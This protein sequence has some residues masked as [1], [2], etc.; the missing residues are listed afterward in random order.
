MTNEQ[1]KAVVLLSGGL[2]STTTLAIAKAQGFSLYALTVDYGQR[3]RFEVLRAREVAER[4]G[5]VE[6]KIIAIDLRTF[7]G[8]SLTSDLAV[9][10]NRSVDELGD[11]IPTTYVPVRNILL[12]SYALAWAEV[13]NASDI[14]IGVNCIDTSGYPD[15]RPEFI[16]AFAAMA[17]LG[18]KLGT[19]LG[20]R[21]SVHAPLQDLN[22][23]QIIRL[24]LQLDVDYGITMTCYAP[25]NDG[26]ACAECDA[27]I[28]RKRGF[29]QAG[30][31]DPIR[32]AK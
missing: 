3:N 6:H 21:I 11:K 30:I 26:T 9:E 24:G 7:G 15:C 17:N 28:L 12:L 25:L 5:V 8:S 20:V 22:K 4:I 29:A 19:E 18:T 23:G 14:F 27:C 31:T 16:D 2:D 32:Y 10:K 1:P 13:L